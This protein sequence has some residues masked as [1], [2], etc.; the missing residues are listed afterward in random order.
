MAMS[1][2]EH[3]LGGD[4]EPL[5]PPEVTIDQPPISA[6]DFEAWHA[7]LALI[8]Q[9]GLDPGEGGQEGLVNDAMPES[10]RA[11]ATSAFDP[12]R[13]EWAMATLAQLKRAVAAQDAQRDAYVEKI[14]RWHRKATV[15]LLDSIRYFE[16]VLQNMLRQSNAEDPEV[17]SVT[18]PS[19]SITSRGPLPGKE[20][21]AEFHPADGDLTVLA[22][23]R[24]H[25]P[26]LV[27]SKEWVLISEVRKRLW[28]VGADKITAAIGDGEER[29]IVEVP[30]LVAYEKRREFKAEPIV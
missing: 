19:G 11:F 14:T 28:K 13:A 15:H 6:E 26:D 3:P 8:D 9:H 25:M 16:G 22:W 30:G 5:L 18:L 1:A 4:L 12:E 24:Q 17:K 20:L 10:M 21:V 29:E 2:P 7:R 23:A 27:H